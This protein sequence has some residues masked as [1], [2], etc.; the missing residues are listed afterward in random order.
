M[1]KKNKNQKI[2]MS[3]KDKELVASQLT[4]FMFDYFQKREK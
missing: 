1:K 2:K 3:Q 4:K